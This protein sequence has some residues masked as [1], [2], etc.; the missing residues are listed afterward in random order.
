MDAD[1]FLSDLRAD[2]ETPLSRLGSSKSLYALTGG[3]MTADAVREAAAAEADAAA[4]RFEAWSADE[5][6]GDAAALF[7]SVAEDARDHR[8]AVAPEGF[9]PDGTREFPEYDALAG[10]KSTPARAGGLLA[11]CVLADARVGQMVGFFVGSADPRAADDFRSLRGDVSDRL[12]D[13]ADLLDAVC[14][15]DGEWAEA[16]E[17]ADAVLEAAYDDYVETLEGMGVKPKNVC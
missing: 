1:T 4:D 17:A 15:N 3:E 9:D 13:A 7:G 12:D 6:S 2:N 10:L 14:E 5:A 16:R 11:R 8:E